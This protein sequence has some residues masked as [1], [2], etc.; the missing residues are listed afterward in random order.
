MV[1]LFG[2]ILKDRC[3]H[4]VAKFYSICYSD[5]IEAKQRHN[6]YKWTLTDIIVVDKQKHSPAVVMVGNGS[7]SNAI[8]KHRPAISSALKLERL[9][10]VWNMV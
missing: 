7:R 10:N 5:F 1:S 6:Q 8:K 4:N 3:E 2:R 9:N